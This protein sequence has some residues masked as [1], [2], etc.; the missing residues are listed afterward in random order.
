MSFTCKYDHSK[1]YVHFLD[2][3]DG[4]TYAVNL[5]GWYW[6]VIDYL[7]ECHPDRWS[8]K[9]LYQ[10]TW[11]IMWH[12][13]GIGIQRGDGSVQAEFV[14]VLK[15]FVYEVWDHV[16]STLLRGHAND[17]TLPITGAR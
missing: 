2:A 17:D 13:W 8:R 11:D 3:P 12:D 9:W 1:N 6:N 10:T 4:I 14:E 16:D 15:R 5:T 7:D